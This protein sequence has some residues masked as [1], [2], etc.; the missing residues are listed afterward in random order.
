MKRVI[1]LFLVLAMI[2]TLAACGSDKQQESTQQ[3]SSVEVSNAESS[4]AKTSESSEQEVAEP[5]KLTVFPLSANTMSGEIGGWLGEF[6]LEHGLI[7]EIM[8][9][10]ADKLNA[11]LA[12]QD[13]PDIVYLP[14]SADFK[15]ISESGMVMDLEPYLN[16]LPHVTDSEMVS[17]ALNYIK[18]YVTDGKLA[19][20]PLNCGPTAYST[21]TSSSI[22]LNWEVYEKIG[23]PEFSTLEELIPILKDMQKAY[24]ESDTGEKM[25]AM[26]LYT[27]ADT[28]YFYGIINIFH[29]SG[30]GADELKYGIEANGID[31]SWD[32]ILADDSMYK[33]ALWY[34]N[35]LYREGL[36]DPNSISTEHGVQHTRIQ[37][38][39]ALAAWNAV[40]GS[41]SNGYYPVYF[42][43][44]TAVANM[45]GYPYG[46]GNYI[47]VSSKTENLDAVLKFLDMAADPEKVRVFN[48]GPQG[49]L[50]DYNDAGEVVLTEKGEATWVNG[51][52]VYIGEEQYAYFNNAWILHPNTIAPDGQAVNLPSSQLYKDIMNNS[53][54]QKKWA[55]HYGYKN[56]ITMIDEKG[57]RI[58]KYG[59]NATKFAGT[60]NDDQNLIIAAA[61]DIIVDASW[62]MVYAESDTDFEKIWDD[63]VKECEELGFKEIFEWRVAELNKGIE[64]RDSLAK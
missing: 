10:S 19:M 53:D 25:Y 6:L 39:G 61:K 33:Y 2:G 22:R 32:W 59:E 48:N 9:H 12:S 40:T 52:T 21:T 35:Q 60:T 37:E 4:E 31:G 50:W 23:C 49:E 44:Y 54:G 47:A 46:A 41:E 14:S 43:D 58:G 30:Y 5:V 36:L 42:E 38:G 28:S 26:H 3:S 34:M 62:K 16:Q 64:I 27:G 57:Q 55:E 45:L 17:T 7:V 13:L 11:I 20:L 24:P 1:S 51:E 8:A 29:I 18:E 63:A 56:L 15:A